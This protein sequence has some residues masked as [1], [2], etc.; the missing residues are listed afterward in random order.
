LGTGIAALSANGD[1]NDAVTA[2]DNSPRGTPAHVQAQQDGL[3]AKN[4]AN[5]LATATDIFLI[6]TLAGAGVTAYF[7]FFDD[8]ESSQVAA[9]PIVTPDT[10][11]VLV[12]GRF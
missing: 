5:R 7:L 10:A 3:S 6:A 11:G 12:S 9:T 2:F 8:G 4:R 1:Y